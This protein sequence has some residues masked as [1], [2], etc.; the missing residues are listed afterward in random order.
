MNTL[1]ATSPD[2]RNWKI[3]AF[4]EPF[5]FEGFSWPVV[6]GTV[7]VLGLTVFLALVSWYVAIGLAILLL[8]WLCERI[9]N[10][11]CPRFRARTEG[12]PPEELT[13]KATSFARRKLEQR[14]ALV[15][16]GGNVELEPPGLKLL[17]HQG[18]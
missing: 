16:A 9:S 15:V 13:W 11:V 8:I 7:V 4:K 2:G 14:I 17:S 10:H 1:A 12:P 3:D 6:I 18:H 5:S